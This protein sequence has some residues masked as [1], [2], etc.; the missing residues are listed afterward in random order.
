[1]VEDDLIQAYRNISTTRIEPILRH[2]IESSLFGIT[3]ITNQYG[4]A[5][6]PV[7]LGGLSHETFTA[8]SS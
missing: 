8:S 1:M 3:L 6:L 7:A 2:V 4:D 5:A